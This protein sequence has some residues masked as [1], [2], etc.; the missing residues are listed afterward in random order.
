MDLF[1]DASFSACCWLGGLALVASTEEQPP[2]AVHVL[3]PRPLTAS[4]RGA[5]GSTCALPAGRRPTARAAVGRACTQQTGGGGGACWWCGRCGRAGRPLGQE[6]VRGALGSLTLGTCL[7]RST[8]T[9]RGGPWPCGLRE[10][11]PLQVPSPPTPSTDRTSCVRPARQGPP[12]REFARSAA[13]SPG[14]VA[15]WCG[16]EDAS[17]FLIVPL[18]VRPW[19]DTSKK[20]A[21]RGWFL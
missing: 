17:V 8:S 1:R 12:R 14:S 5:S 20:P 4:R 10:R 21:R 16:D 6:L 3:S 2:G 18:A 15:S 11:A 19:S 13:L 7:Q 9:P